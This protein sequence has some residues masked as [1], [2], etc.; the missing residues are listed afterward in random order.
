M[1]KVK[2]FDDNVIASIK[3]KHLDKFHKYLSAG[4]YL[5]A[6]IKEVIFSGQSPVSGFGRYQ[7]YSQSYKDFLEGKARFYSF[8]SGKV[9]RVEPKYSARSTPKANKS[10]GYKIGAK[11]SIKQDKFARPFP[12]KKTSPVNL[13][14]TGEMMSTLKLKKDTSRQ[15]IWVGFFGS[16]VAEYHDKLGAS[17]KK[18]IRRLLPTRQG[19]KFKSNISSGIKQYCKQSLTEVLNDNRLLLTIRFVFSTKR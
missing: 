3:L 18:V 11:T 13:Y 7:K 5:I 8:K 16:K 1:A 19:E 14:A 2:F 15:V 4:D 17:R 12:N 6:K 10:G 9:V